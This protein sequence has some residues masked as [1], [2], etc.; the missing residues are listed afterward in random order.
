MP[1]NK[2]RK[3][4]LFLYLQVHKYITFKIEN[5]FSLISPIFEKSAM[6]LNFQYDLYYSSTF[7]I[8]FQPNM[9]EQ[10]KKRQ[11]IYDLLNAK[12]KTNL[13]CLPYKKRRKI[14]CRKVDFK[15]KGGGRWRIKQKKKQNKTK[16]LFNCYSDK[17][18]TLMI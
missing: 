5:V 3:K 17:E 10:E 14:F 2:E 8:K 6:T 13:L 11:G 15:G 1:L 16:R 9:N 18:S 12:T 4:T 7:K